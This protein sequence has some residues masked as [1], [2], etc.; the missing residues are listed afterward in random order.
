[1]V[2]LS[3]HPSILRS[4]LGV[5]WAE[6]AAKASSRRLSAPSTRNVSGASLLLYS[7][8]HAASPKISGG[9]TRRRWLFITFSSIQPEAAG[10]D[11]ASAAGIERARPGSGQ[12][13]TVLLAEKHPLRIIRQTQTVGWGGNACLHRLHQIGSD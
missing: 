2:P 7:A 10:A 13:L 6:P 5:R 11:Q 8:A 3:T 1:M 12:P 9:T 4:S